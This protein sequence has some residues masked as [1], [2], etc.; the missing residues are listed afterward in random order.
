VKFEFINKVGHSYDSC[1]I[2]IRNYNDTGNFGMAFYIFGVL[3]N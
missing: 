3:N 2:L 1:N